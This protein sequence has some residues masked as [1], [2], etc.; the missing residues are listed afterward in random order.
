MN[1]LS[2]TAAA[3]PSPVR[4]GG[5]PL[6]TWSDQV[7]FRHGQCDPAGIVYTP[8][9]FDVASRTLEQWF[10][11]RLG[12]DYYDIIG[13]R[14][15]G[16]GYATATAAFFA[17]CQMGDVIEICVCLLR[18]GEKSYSL[19]LPGFR[20]GEEV[21][22]VEFTTVTTRLGTHG[23]VA[24]PTDIAEALRGYQRNQNG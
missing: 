11:A 19:V 7:T 6:G 22:R 12:L 20:A 16:L 3:R 9:F 17:P 24:I 1:L 4:R 2:L 13:R 15:I 8:N 14:Q 18:V 21:F 10:Q 23:A 5:L